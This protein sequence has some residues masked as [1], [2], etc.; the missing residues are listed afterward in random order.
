LARLLRA[1][2]P[3]ARGVLDVAG[4][5][6]LRED[7]AAPGGRQ[8]VELDARAGLGPRGEDGAALRG[9]LRM[10]LAVLDDD[11]N[12]ALATAAAD[13]DPTADPSADA[14]S[15]DRADA[16]ALPFGA[17]LRDDPLDGAVRRLLDETLRASD[18]D[19]AASSSGLQLATG[20]DAW[21][22]QRAM[23]VDD[24]ALDGR[25]LA[26]LVEEVT[27]GRWGAT[28]LGVV[29]DGGEG[30]GAIQRAAVRIERPE[31]ELLRGRV[32]FTVRPL[33]DDVARVVLLLDGDQAAAIDQPPFT[34]R[35]DLGR[36]LRRRV[37]SAVAYDADGA[38]LGRE[39][40]VLNGG[41]L[42]VDIVSPTRAAG[43]GPVTVEAEIAVPLENRLDRVLFFWNDEAVATRFAPP[44]RQTVLIPEDA[45]VGF[46]RVVAM[47][48]DGTLAED[49]LLLNG[50]DSAAQ[51]DV[52]LVELNVV[53]TDREGRPV[54]GL[55]E[56]D[57]AVFEDGTPRSLAT[58]SDA[59]N[60]PL[61]VG[62]A[63]DSSASMFVKM[64]RVQ[65]AAGRFLRSIFEDQ[66]RGFIVDIDTQPRLARS[67]VDEL[68]PL[69]RAIDDLAPDGRTA[70][71]ESVVFSLVHLQGVR[72]RKA[73]IV[74]SDG[75]DEDDA[76]PF[77][78]CL[79]MARRMGVPIYLILLKEAPDEG[80]EGLLEGL[81]NRAFDDRADQL[82]SAVGGRVYYADDV[83]DLDGVYDAIENELRSQYLLAY[84]AEDGGAGAAGDW[85]RVRVEVDRPGL[86]PRTLTGYWP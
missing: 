52:N 19:A 58:F 16:S 8:G 63:I 42:A 79:R 20:T 55:T 73:L 72:G 5:L 59:E 9:P 17:S 37:L 18:A 75:A 22:W 67:I 7:L 30:L 53:V 46:V 70:L 69:L 3:D 85:R 6:R 28:L 29:R 23:A 80:D 84:Y 49:V 11:G 61:T 57:F 24:P 10:T 71:W 32:P 4:E 13:V 82:V 81:W 36:D 50:P 74:F 12:L 26:L 44:Y 33:R 14:D 86:K 31:R 76:F 68:P 38:E 2:A 78:N 64:P 15:S 27:T 21:R 35:L 65:R 43:T 34:A 39:L 51:I 83:G 41:A 66:D 60:L 25:P 47:L 54:Q 45:P 1:P 62:L 48:D 77:R 56:A 40:V